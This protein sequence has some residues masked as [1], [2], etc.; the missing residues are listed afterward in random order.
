LQF[1]SLLLEDS[2]RPHPRPPLGSENQQILRREN[3]VCVIGGEHH[4][5]WP[6][7]SQKSGRPGLVT[8][9]TDSRLIEG[10]DWRTD[11]TWE[12]EGVLQNVIQGGS[13][14]NSFS[15]DMCICNK[16]LLSLL[17]VSPVLIAHESM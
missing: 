16:D 11:E 9:R 17:E 3:S 7:V 6:I 1:H 12:N 8:L 10:V 2:L 4:S 14:S 15:P 5:L 13:K